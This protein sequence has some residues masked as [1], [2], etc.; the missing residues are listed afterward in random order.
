MGGVG[1]GRAIRGVVVGVVLGAGTMVRVGTAAVAI[2]STTDGGGGGRATTSPT[3]DVHVVV[4]GGGA[5]G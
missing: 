4:V 3:D 1:V 5:R 2:A